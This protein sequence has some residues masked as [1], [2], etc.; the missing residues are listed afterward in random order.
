MTTTDISSI[1]RLVHALEALN[2]PRLAN[3]TTR[4]R[5]GIYDDFRSSLPKPKVTLIMELRALGQGELADRVAGGEFDSTFEEAMDWEESTE[6]RQA[7]AA[8]LMDA[9]QKRNANNDYRPA[10]NIEL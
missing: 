8:Q 3:I 5:R 7:M 1:E 6:G 4:A 10:Q 2:D 9:I